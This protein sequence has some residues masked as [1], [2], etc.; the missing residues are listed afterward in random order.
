LDVAMIV[1]LTGCEIQRGFELVNVGEPCVLVDVT[2]MLRDPSQSQGPAAS[3]S[4]ACVG[5]QKL[6]FRKF[7]SNKHD[8]WR[9]RRETLACCDLQKGVQL[10]SGVAV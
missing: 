7:S 1:A 9:G 3:L 10:V 4:Y 2:L 5:R 8:P 6:S